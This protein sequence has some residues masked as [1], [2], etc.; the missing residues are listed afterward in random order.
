MSKSLNDDTELL[1]IEYVFTRS[2]EI[3]GEKCSNIY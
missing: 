2:I 1:F 3:H